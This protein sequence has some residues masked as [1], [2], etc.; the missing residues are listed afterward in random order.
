MS[1]FR[2]SKGLNVDRLDHSAYKAIRQQILE[3]AL[4]PGEQLVE[5]QLADALGMSRTPVRNALLRLEHERLVT[6]TAGSGTFVSPIS[7]VDVAEI[8]DLR[9]VIEGLAARLLA[10]RITKGE[11][12]YLMELAEK[13][14][15]ETAT[16]SD[17]AEFHSAI[18]RLCGNNRLAD[19]VDK[20]C[21]QSLTFDRRSRQMVSNGDVHVLSDERDT[22]AHKA[23][24]LKITS[25]D[26]LGAEESI[27]MYIRHGK[28]VLVKMLMG[29]EE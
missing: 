12:S 8:Y 16:L 3:G 13:A 25:G 26:A 19:F 11:A 9:E 2:R 1:N 18:V 6:S 10:R 29:L 28:N 7:A 22:D 14:D 24:A 21:L 5:T 27:K 23:V 20:F 4:R 17:D 15:A